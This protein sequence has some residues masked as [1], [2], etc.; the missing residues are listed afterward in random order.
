VFLPYTGELG[1]I[2]HL[3]AFL[4]RYQEALEREIGLE[5]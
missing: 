3:G 4:I 1:D 2:I 5:L